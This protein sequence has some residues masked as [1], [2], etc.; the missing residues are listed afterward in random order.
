MNIGIVILNYLAYNVT[1]EC[2]RSFLQQEFFEDNY[3]IVIVDNASNNESYSVLKETFAENERIKVVQTHK[4]LG[5]AKGNNFGY[6][7]LLQEFIPD[8]L[9]VSNDDVVLRTSGLVSWIKKEYEKYEFAVLGPSVFSIHGNFFQ[10]P[11]TNLT[12]DPHVCRKIM[13]RCFLRLIRLYVRKWRKEQ[14]PQQNTIG[15]SDLKQEKTTQYTLHGSF[16]VFSSRY[17]SYYSE[18]YDPR[19]FLYREEDILKLRCDIAGI[20]MLFSPDYSVDHYQAVAT[21]M[22]STN[23]YDKRIKR[24]KYDLYSW[25]VYYKL[26]KR[27]KHIGRI[28]KPVQ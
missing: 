22:V 26:L 14:L 19:T 10:S 27:S 18:P 2:V 4:N 7:T 23:A 20:P 16:Q 5:F 8:F 1:I 12:R 3:L 17:F 9:I 11:M 21:N 6:Y 28:T 24:T 13:V 25:I 15:K